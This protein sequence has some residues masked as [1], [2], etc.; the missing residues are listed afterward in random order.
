[1][2]ENFCPQCKNDSYLKPNIK[3]LIS[4]C[5]HKMCDM[6]VSRIFAHGPA[7]CPECGVT[8]RKINF[9]SQTF[10]DVETERECRI[11]KMVLKIF[12]KSEEHFKTLEEYDDYLE[13]IENVVFEC[14]ELKTDMEITN[15]LEKH[16]K[17]NDNYTKEMHESSSAE[18]DNENIS[19][20]DKKKKRLR[21]NRFLDE[22]AQSNKSYDELIKKLYNPEESTQI[23]EEFNPLKDIEEPVFKLTKKVHIP[24][25]LEK[26]NKAGGYTKAITMYKAIYSVFDSEI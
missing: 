14:K 15:L 22:V 5:Y 3:I 10:E 16:K 23:E 2:L 19:V 25:S 13:K 20:V 24:K 26:E 21:L 11:R 8:I 6:C 18:E 7:P 4:P 17:D 1:M 9:I 12:N